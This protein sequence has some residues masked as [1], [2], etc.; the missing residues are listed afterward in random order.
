MKCATYD[1][2]PVSR[3]EQ[4]E[5]DDLNKS[6]RRDKSTNCD[7]PTGRLSLHKLKYSLHLI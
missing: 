4:N 7:S 6:T 2:F 5:V 3:R 1:I